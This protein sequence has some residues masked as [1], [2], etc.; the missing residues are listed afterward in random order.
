MTTFEGFRAFYSEENPSSF[1]VRLDF[2]SAV[3]TKRTKE[4]KTK[5]LLLICKCSFSFVN[6][7]RYNE[8]NQEDNVF[9]HSVILRDEC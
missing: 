4:P 2:L 8:N 6:K 1:L 5:P 3:S 9:L 7:T